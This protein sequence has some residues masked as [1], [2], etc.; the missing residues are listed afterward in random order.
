MESKSKYNFILSKS[1]QLNMTEYPIVPL[2]YADLIFDSFLGYCVLFIN[3]S[4]KSQKY[5]NY[6]HNLWFVD[7]IK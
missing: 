6:N 3:N 5:L 1:S 4:D 7:G 2:Y